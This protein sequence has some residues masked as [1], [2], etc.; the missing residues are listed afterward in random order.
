MKQT[1]LSKAFDISHDTL[2]THV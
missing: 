1:M 2:C